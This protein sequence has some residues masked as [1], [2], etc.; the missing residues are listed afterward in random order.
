MTTPKRRIDHLDTLHA[1]A[2][3]VP[4]DSGEEDMVTCTECGLAIEEAKYLAA[5]WTDWI[6]L[7]F[8]W[9]CEH[10]PAEDAPVRLASKACVESFCEQHPQYREEIVKLMSDYERECVHRSE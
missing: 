4:S 10:F 7:K 9:A 1:L 8:S 2:S 6:T 3:I 5:R